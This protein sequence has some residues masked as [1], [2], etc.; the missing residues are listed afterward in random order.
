M[1]LPDWKSGNPALRTLGYRLVRVG[2]AEPKYPREDL[3]GTKR[4]L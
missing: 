4:P 1:A 3:F 2:T